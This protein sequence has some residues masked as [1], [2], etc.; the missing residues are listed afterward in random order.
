MTR[1][2][3]HSACGS[4]GSVSTGRQLVSPAGWIAP[5]PSHVVK[6]RSSTPSSGMTAKA[7]KKTS[8]GSASQ[9]TGPL[10]PPPWADGCTA[11]PCAGGARAVICR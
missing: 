7:T 10:R 2:V 1:K 4:P 5:M 11:P 9:A 8:A 6:L 3:T